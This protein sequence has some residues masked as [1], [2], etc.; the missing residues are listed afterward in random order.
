MKS[1]A[2]YND[3]EICDCLAITLKTNKIFIFSYDLYYETFI[4]YVK[5]NNAC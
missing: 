3:E 1:V 2:A 5:I 4:K